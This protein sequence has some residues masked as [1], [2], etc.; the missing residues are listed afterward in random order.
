LHVA[1]MEEVRNAYSILVGECE[2]NRPL[3]R[4]GRVIL[5]WI[6]RK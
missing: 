6:L 4:V 3:R 1:G 5:Q 2:V